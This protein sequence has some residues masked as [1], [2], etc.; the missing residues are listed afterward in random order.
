M[1]AEYDDFCEEL[2]SRPHYTVGTVGGSF[3]NMV[4]RGKEEYVQVGRK[5]MD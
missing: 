1:L 2:T 5:K 3:R 4:L